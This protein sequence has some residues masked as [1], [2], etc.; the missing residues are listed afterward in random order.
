MV[1]GNKQKWAEIL[2]D[3]RQANG[4]VKVKMQVLGIKAWPERYFNLRGHTI[5]QWL[6]YMTS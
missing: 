6:I 2:E 5:C 1:E 3:V 4:A